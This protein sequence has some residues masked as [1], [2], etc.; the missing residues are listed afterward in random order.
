METYRLLNFKDITDKGLT[1]YYLETLAIRDGPPRKTENY[2]VRISGFGLSGEGRSI[3]IYYNTM[4]IFNQVLRTWIYSQDITPLTIFEEHRQEFY[5]GP[6]QLL[7]GDIVWVQDLVDP[8]FR[9][10]YRNRDTLDPIDPIKEDE[11]E[12]LKKEVCSF[13]EI[14]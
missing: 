4:R 6:F 3:V 14:T 8:L 10:I 5:L 2:R 1:G 7:N 11:F 9:K 13:G 12:A